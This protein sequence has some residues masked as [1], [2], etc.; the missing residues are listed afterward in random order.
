LD[1]ATLAVV[2]GRPAHRPGA[3]VNT[4]I[5]LS[6]TFR[7]GGPAVYGR[8]DND[9]RESFELALGGLEGGIAL[10]FGSGMAAIAATV[11][12]LPIGGP[13]V[14]GAAYNGTRRLLADSR[15]RGRLTVSDADVADTESTLAVCAKA[16]AAFACAL[17]PSE[18][19]TFAS[20]GLL[21]L[22]SPTNPLLAV[23][24]LAALI[25]G[26]HDLGL[27]VAVDNTFA[28]PLLQRPLDLGADVVVH[29]VTKMLAGHSDLLMGA[30]VTT[31]APLADRL[32]SRRSLHGAIPGPFE[33]FLALRGLRTLS[34][35]LERAQ[36]N[37]GAIAHRLASR[38]GVSGV[39]YPGLPDDPGHRLAA[40]QMRGFGT[41]VAFEVDGGADAAEAVCASV[42]VLTPATSLGGVE[43]LIERRGRYVGESHLPPG[44]LRLSVGIEALEDLWADLDQAIGSATGR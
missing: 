11:E 3:A 26:A 22:E 7:A 38:L 5:V 28:T 41:M 33:A 8:D 10:A 4:P 32:A 14:V 39:R 2:L 35:R 19:L 25:A 17:G 27:S 43:S 34:V 30:T 18:Q 21:W 15:Q 6:S 42:R 23:A 13:V 40:R 29:S 9:T 44:L 31:S 36:A 1:P 16:V 37:A 24:D 20:G 12:L